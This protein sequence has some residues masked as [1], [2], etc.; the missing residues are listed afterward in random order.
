MVSAREQKSDLSPSY[1]PAGDKIVFYSN[2]T[3][4][5]QIFEM[6][7]EQPFTRAQFLDKMRTAVR[8]DTF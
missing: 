8:E 2:R 6:N 3:G 4:K 7:V 1:S 5:Y